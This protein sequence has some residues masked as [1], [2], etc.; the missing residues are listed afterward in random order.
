MAPPQ[1][2]PVERSAAEWRAKVIEHLMAAEDALE[3]IA[4]D[5]SWKGEVARSHS[6]AASAIANA[7]AAKVLP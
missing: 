2:P 4:E 1:P 3:T 5:F 7:L 6:L